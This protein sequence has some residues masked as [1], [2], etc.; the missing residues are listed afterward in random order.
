M[1]VGARVEIGLEVEPVGAVATRGVAGA[2]VTWVGASISSAGA[3][4]A[5]VVRATGL[6]LL[7]PSVE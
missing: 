4:V 6:L 2:P 1:W 7:K 3:G 5:A